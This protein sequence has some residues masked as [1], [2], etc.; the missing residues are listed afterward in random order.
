MPGCLEGFPLVPP[1]DPTTRHQCVRFA[2]R[3]AQDNTPCLRHQKPPLAWGPLDW[4]RIVQFSE[5]SL[6]VCARTDTAA[7]L[8]TGQWLQVTDAQSARYVPMRT[9][10]R[11]GLRL[12]YNYAEVINERTMSMLPTF[13]SA[14]GVGAGGFWCVAHG[15][16]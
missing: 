10:F 13:V 11:R 1:V 8:R 6:E 2:R 14:V 12:R 15:T 16:T 7:G 3:G 9:S 5:Q 4:Q